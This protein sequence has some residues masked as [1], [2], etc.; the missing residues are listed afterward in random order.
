MIIK[1]IQV[2]LVLCVLSI[3]SPTVNAWVYY[4]HAKYDFNYTKI[5]SNSTA[6]VLSGDQQTLNALNLRLA[7]DNKW[8]RI[9]VDVH[10]EI[11]LLRS[12]N[13]D[14]SAVDRDRFRLF[15][16]SS[17]IKDESSMQQEHRL[18][19][20]SISY[21]GDDLVLRLGRQAVSWG[22]GIVFHP[23]DIFNPFD[24]VAIDKD[25]KTGDDM[26]YA[27]WLMDDGNDLQLIALPGRNL[28]GDVDNDQSSLA[29]KYHALSQNGDIDLLVAQHYDSHYYALG[30]ARSVVE[31]VWRLDIMY[32]ETVS[33]ESR[34]SLVT[35][36]DYSWVW[37][38]HNIYGFVEYFYSGVGDA[39][40]TLTP[41]PEL[42]ARLARGEV[43]NL[44]R[45]YLAIGLNI[46]LHPLV[47]LMPTLITN[48]NDQSRLMQTTLSYDWKENVSLKA[49]LLL[50]S[51]ESDSEYGGIFY[52]G[53]QFNLLIACYF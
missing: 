14:L 48:L 13:P 16:L 9:G 35:N 46:E 38:E 11:N 47:N 2:I 36:M 25:Y 5:A 29:I 51:G 22:N 18:D 34:H 32:S 8:D 33:G 12:N 31:A 17:S 28:S 1:K 40:Y 24:P 37:F 41:N 7:A 19:R 6:Y 39:D 4:G 15:D 42:S 21:N 20:L 52:P 50:A 45:D 44:A 3:I 27:Q 53:D 10:Y 49:S 43:F 30:Y 23:L 26:L